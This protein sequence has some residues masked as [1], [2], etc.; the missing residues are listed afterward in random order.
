LDNIEITTS[1]A[2]VQNSINIDNEL[3][4]TIN[5]AILELK[6]ENQ[7]IFKL[8][9]FNLVEISHKWFC[10]TEKKDYR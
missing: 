1:N 4:S 8:S 5:S 3:E 9:A 7:S 2:K 10:W 6:E